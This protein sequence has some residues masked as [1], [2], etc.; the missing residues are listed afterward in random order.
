LFKYYDG[1]MREMDEEKQVLKPQ[2]KKAV[3]ITARII[4]QLKPL[5]QGV[6]IMPLGWDDLIPEI[7]KEAELN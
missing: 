7:I 1:A 4:R 2:K 6:H 3:N 5:C